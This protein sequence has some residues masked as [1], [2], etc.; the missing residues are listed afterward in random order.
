MSFAL[1]VV[2]LE[3]RIIWLRSTFDTRSW[4][5]EYGIL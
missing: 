5:E 1:C 4:T 2:G 3:P